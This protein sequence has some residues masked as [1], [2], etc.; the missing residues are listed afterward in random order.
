[1]KHF[2]TLALIFIGFASASTAAVHIVEVAPTA[3]PLSFSPLT[4]NAVPGDTVRFM[5]IGGSAYLITHDL[6]VGTPAWTPIS[7]AG[8]DTEGEFT[9]GGPGTYRF[10]D[11]NFQVRDTGEIIVA[12]PQITQEVRSNSTQLSVWPNPFSERV[13]INGKGLTFDRAEVFS[14]SGKLVA[15]F[16]ANAKEE[17]MVIELNGVATGQY[18]L[19]LMNGQA[20]VARKELVRVN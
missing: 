11:D 12:Y 4:V 10:I 2:F 20:L 7:L 5:K 17:T 8:N 16:P 13:T 14:M 1:M 9:V 18:M 15:T 6:T 3:N 19:R